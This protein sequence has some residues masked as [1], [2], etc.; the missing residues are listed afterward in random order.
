LL[1]WD[2]KN[3][4]DYLL[5]WDV[6][7][8]VIRPLECT[9]WEVF[10]GSYT[11]AFDKALSTSCCAHSAICRSDYVFTFHIRI[12]PVESQARQAADR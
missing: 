3:V 8:L 1:A 12:A 6:K 7:A 9:P 11:R 2:V 4:S 10:S 5:A